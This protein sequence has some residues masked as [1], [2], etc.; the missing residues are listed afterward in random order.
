V[1]LCWRPPDAEEGISGFYIEALIEKAVPGS[2]FVPLAFD[3]GYIALQD[4]PEGLVGVRRIVFS[5]K[6]HKPRTTGK[7]PMPSARDE[8]SEEHITILQQ[9]SHVTARTIIDGVEF[10]DDNTGWTTCSNEA[11]QQRKVQ[12]LVLR[13]GTTTLGQTT[14]GAYVN[15]GTGWRH[16]ASVSVKSG[17]PFNDFTS[18]IED[19]RRDGTSVE[20]ERRAQYG[21][22]WF[23]I[24]NGTWKACEAATFRAPT[25]ADERPDNIYTQANPK[26][27]SRVLA[28]GGDLDGE[29]KLNKEYPISQPDGRPKEPPSLPAFP[30]WFTEARRQ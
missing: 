6:Y 30:E 5:L 20:E 15:V 8:N 16:L 21:P 7:E 12:C 26:T 28:T 24:D 11:D 1:S 17:R 3:G 4:T 10:R 23:L 9:G 27:G 2:H 25:F 22:T 18:S 14:Y 13:V 29:K 19:F